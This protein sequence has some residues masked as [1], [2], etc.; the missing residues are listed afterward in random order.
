[1]SGVSRFSMMFYWH[2]YYFLPADVLQQFK[3]CENLKSEHYSDNML[4]KSEIWHIWVLDHRL[5]SNKLGGD[6]LMEVCGGTPSYFVA[7]N[8]IWNM[9][10][11]R[12]ESHTSLFK[13]QWCTDIPW[14]W[15][16]IKVYFQ[17]ETLGK[18]HTFTLITI[19]CYRQ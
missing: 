18:N 16:V 6:Q 3:E 1:M 15:V 4:I 8:D 2:W 14:Y 11:F 19:S 5:S 9:C 10:F 7:K 13:F 17:P 12:I